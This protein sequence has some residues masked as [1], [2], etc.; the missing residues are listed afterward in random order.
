MLIDGNKMIEVLG[1]PEWDD[2]I[3]DIIEEF[4]EERPTLDED[5]FTVWMRPDGYDVEL[6]FDDTC[7]NVQQREREGERN[8][9]LNQISV[10]E[11]TTLK[12]PF[13]IE[14]GDNYDTI[15]SKIGIK[16]YAK[17]KLM[18][19][20]FHWLLEDNT[21]KYFLNCEFTDNTA[22]SLEKLDL[23]LFDPKMNYSGMIK[24]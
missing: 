18:D 9:Y 23:G 14:M 20:R 13:E 3:I 16:A 10:E 21:K 22:K 7:N 15:T 11:D 4:G 8:I 5:T 12:L 24:I 2:K 6:A 17:N 19:Y 1:L